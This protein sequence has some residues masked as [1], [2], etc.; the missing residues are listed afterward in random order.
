M[1]HL[2]EII[3]WYALPAI[4]KEISYILKKK[5]FR[6]TEISHLL[7][8]TPAAVSQY[9]YSKR[10]G[11]E[12]PEEVKSFIKKVLKSKKRDEISKKEIDKLINDSIKILIENRHLCDFCVEA[13]YVMNDEFCDKCYR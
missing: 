12:L 3:T 8:I 4:R 1:P 7:D 6:V 13:G 10:K 5:K 2:Y 9:L 11:M